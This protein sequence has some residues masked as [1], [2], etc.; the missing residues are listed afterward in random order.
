MPEEA[1]LAAITE[2]ALSESSLKE[3]TLL[4]QPPKSRR[5]IPKHILLA[6]YIPVRPLVR[7]FAWRIR[8]FLTAELQTRL[9]NI[10][11]ALA[12][13][14]ARS[15]EQPVVTAATMAEFG[16]MLEITLLALA[17]D[18]PRDRG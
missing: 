11:N 5:S 14:Q 10:E 15:G 17:L 18:H 1:A 6:L 3:T 13:I 2:L 4:S 16:R 7:P 12:Q 8:T 9:R